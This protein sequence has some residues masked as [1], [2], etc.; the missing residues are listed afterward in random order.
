MFPE[1]QSRPFRHHTQFPLQA[2]LGCSAQTRKARSSFVT[3]THQSVSG[4]VARLNL[5][6]PTW[7]LA[8]RAIPALI[9]GFPLPMRF[10]RL[11]VCLSLRLPEG[12]SCSK[13]GGT[14]VPTAQPTDLEAAY[15]CAHIS[16][17]VLAWYM[18][19]VLRVTGREWRCCPLGYTTHSISTEQVRHATCQLLI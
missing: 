10:L 7:P 11:S 2:R 14:P 13:H 9:P 15:P 1:I 18:L 17:I 4:A 16:S 8:K 6:T 12:H 3:D 5:G 19:G